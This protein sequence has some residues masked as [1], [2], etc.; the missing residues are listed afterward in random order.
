MLELECPLQ[1]RVA[2]VVTDGLEDQE[3]EGHEPEVL[4]LS[5]HLWC[6]PPGL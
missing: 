2:P 5:Q 1:G 6:L 4:L 3:S